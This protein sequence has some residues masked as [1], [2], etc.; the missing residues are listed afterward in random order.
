MILIDDIPFYYFLHQVSREEFEDMT[1]TIIRK[2]SNNLILGISDE[3]QPL[4]DVEKL[5]LVPK[6]VEKFDDL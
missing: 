6:L 2:F 1:R 4:G 3:M 5:R